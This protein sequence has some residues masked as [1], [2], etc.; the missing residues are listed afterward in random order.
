MDAEGLRRSRTQALPCKKVKLS[1]RPGSPLPISEIS[2]GQP[3]PSSVSEGSVADDRTREQDKKN[4]RAHRSPAAVSEAQIPE[5]KQILLHRPAQTASENFLVAQ[6]R[7]AR[8]D[9]SFGPS[10]ALARRRRSRQQARR[11][12]A[13]RRGILSSTPLV[14]RFGAFLLLL[15]FYTHKCLD[16]GFSRF[17][18]RLSASPYRVGNNEKPSYPDG[19]GPRRRLAG[20]RVPHAPSPPRDSAE[21]NLCSAIERAVQTSR[22]VASRTVQEESDDGTEPGPSAPPADATAFQS[23]RAPLFVPFDPETAGELGFV[24]DPG[25]ISYLLFS[26]DVA[27]G[28]SRDDYTQS[29]VATADETRLWLEV[30]EAEE[31]KRL[32]SLRVGMSAFDA[33]VPP[34]WS[35]V[36]ALL[37]SAT[38]GQITLM[39]MS[40]VLSDHGVSKRLSLSRVAKHTPTVALARELRRGWGALGLTRPTLQALLRQAV[41][42]V[43]EQ[44]RASRVKLFWDLMPGGA[45]RIDPKA[46][47]ALAA[48]ESVFAEALQ[49]WDFLKR[50]KG[51]ITAGKV[52]LGAED[53]RG[54]LGQI[55][56]SDG[57]LL[58]LKR[59]LKGCMPTS[60]SRRRRT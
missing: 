58:F 10:S 39:R 41:V 27:A 26:N 4:A 53:K 5:G 35:Q 36:N 51:W 59:K 30:L 23:A 28:I 46:H 20:E 14:F 40:R 49:G 31:R 32:E 3:V 43:G 42:T 55:L 33:G 34:T 1:S 38:Q 7:R 21:E 25:E 18:S 17:M 8:E 11:S 24:E 44:T 54:P 60:R 12:A 16:R 2:K 15:T 50:L 37:V 48:E 45:S 52:T 29:R 13:G 6:G 19:H 47:K 57:K 9:A 56:A 22:A